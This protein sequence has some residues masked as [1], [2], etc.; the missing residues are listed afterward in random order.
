MH[1]YGAKGNFGPRPLYEVFSEFCACIPNIII[2]A[3]GQRSH[4]T[5]PEQ[6]KLIYELNSARP[7]YPTDKYEFYNGLRELRILYHGWNNLLICACR[8][9]LHSLSLS[10]VLSL[11]P[12]LV[13]G[14]FLWCVVN[15]AFS[16][17]CGA[18]RLE[19]IIFRLSIYWGV[20]K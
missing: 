1:D 15:E 20:A 12:P 8:I 13:T 5:V 6:S 9:T 16:H 11:F 7:P 18:G 17:R 14:I 4:Y 10:L 2:Y 19:W 3:C